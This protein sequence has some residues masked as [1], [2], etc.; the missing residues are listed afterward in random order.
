MVYCVLLFCVC[1]RHLGD[2]TD[3]MKAVSVMEGGSI[4]L[5]TDVS[6]VQRCFL[7]Q[8]MFG[9]IRI[10]EVNRLTQTN[11]TYGGPEE[12]FRDRLHLDQAGSLTIKNTRNTD[13][14]LYRL[15][16]ISRE[17]SYTT[18]S[19][20]VY[21][22]LHSSSSPES[23]SS[24]N[25]VLS[26]CVVNSSAINNTNSANVTELQSCSDRIHCCGFTE[27]VIRLVA[28]ALVSLAAVS[29]LVYDIKSTRNELNRMEET[30]LKHRTH[31]LKSDQQYEL[32]RRISSRYVC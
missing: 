26:S 22:A 21:E 30:R 11:S 31:G 23:S 20:E 9:S 16:I 13:S 6:D 27:T 25:F 7:I 12:R 5:H 1:L 24:S 3:E 19:V 32:S 14:G 28:S 2:A 17:T 10:A 8:W 4:T 15:T 29:F 18:Y